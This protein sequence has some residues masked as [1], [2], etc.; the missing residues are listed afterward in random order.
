[1]MREATF[2]Y[3]ASSNSG[4]M[5]DDIGCSSIVVS[6]SCACSCMALGQ[7]VTPARGPEQ[8]GAA[9][10][11]V[12]TGAMEGTLGFRTSTIER[13]RLPCVGRLK[14]RSQ[15]AAIHF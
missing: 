10:I 6:F 3:V 5:A 2:L 11:L 1:M 13:I 9:G 14:R 4:V 12:R 15:R 8:S 7:D